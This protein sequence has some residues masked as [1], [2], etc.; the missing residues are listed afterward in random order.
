MDG[1]RVWKVETPA[2]PVIQ[3]FFR[4]R[5]GWPREPLK[6]LFTGLMGRKTSPTAAGRHATERRLLS[7]WREAGLDVPAELSAEHPDQ[8]GPAT[9]VLEHVDGPTLLER[10]KRKAGL[11]RAERDPLLRRFGQ[12]W[13]AR[14]DLALARDDASFLQ[15]HGSLGHVLLCGERMVTF[16]LEQAYRPGVPVF[17]VLA[18]EVANTLRSLHP[19]VGDELFDDDL[20]ALV[21]GYGDRERLALVCDEYLHNPSAL[22]RLLWWCDRKLEARLTRRSSK[23]TVLERLEAVLAR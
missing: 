20:A 17:P 21:E 9:L 4:P 5:G 1:N 13:R 7:L 15:E 2:G 11:S 8:R 19:R 3:K 23:Y 16:D 6:A 18:K 12:Q 14:H 10:V 22:R